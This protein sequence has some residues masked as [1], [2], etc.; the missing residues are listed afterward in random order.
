MKNFLK[1]YLHTWFQKDCVVYDGKG[2]IQGMGVQ[3]VVDRLLILGRP[4][5][6]DVYFSVDAEWTSK[7]M[8]KLAQNDEQQQSWDNY[9]KRK[10]ESKQK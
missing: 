1:K 9:M 4:F 8:E 7:L 3:V 2:Y 10:Q 6:T 5:I